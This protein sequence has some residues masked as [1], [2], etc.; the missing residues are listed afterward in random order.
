MRNL[1]YTIR[2]FFTRQL[3]LATIGA[4]LGIAIIML[5]AIYGT[6]LTIAERVAVEVDEAVY[7]IEEG[8]R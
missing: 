1:L 8:E 6:M 5:V 2:V 7:A 4:V 3:R